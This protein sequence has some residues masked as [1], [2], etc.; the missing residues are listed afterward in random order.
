[1]ADV[2]PAG[3]AHARED[4]LAGTGRGAGGSRGHR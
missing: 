4:A 2:Q 3:R 1:M